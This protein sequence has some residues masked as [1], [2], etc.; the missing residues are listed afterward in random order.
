MNSGELSH[1]ATHAVHPPAPQRLQ[2]TVNANLGTIDD[3]TL[4][5]EDSTEPPA[6]IPAQADED[7]DIF[8]SVRGNPGQ[9]FELEEVTHHAATQRPS[10][11]R[12]RQKVPDDH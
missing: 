5:A 2:Y 12:R 4:S 6:L 8:Y 10:H 3:H 1:E 9:E 11:T 7:G